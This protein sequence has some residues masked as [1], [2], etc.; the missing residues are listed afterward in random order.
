MF[1]LYILANFNYLL[2]APEFLVLVFFFSSR[3]VVSFTAV[4]ALYQVGEEEVF[5]ESIIFL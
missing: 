2:P 4:Y 1:N 3:G 5:Y